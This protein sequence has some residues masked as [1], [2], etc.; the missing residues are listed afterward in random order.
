MR[1][2]YK[3]GFNVLWGDVLNELWGLAFGIGWI[4]GAST[5]EGLLGCWI[6]PLTWR[7]LSKLRF[8]PKPTWD[9]FRQLSVVQIEWALRLIN[10]SLLLTKDHLV[11]I[12]GYFSTIC[13]VPSCWNWSPL[14]TMRGSPTIW[15]LK[16]CQVFCGPF[17]KITVTCI[18]FVFVFLI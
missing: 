2:N 4:Y 17:K 13:E 6:K 16:I 8:I 7:L 3:D 11:F 10:V 9:K 12:L 5:L 14:A 18:F 15:T 1:V